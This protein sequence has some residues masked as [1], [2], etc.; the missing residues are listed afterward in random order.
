M[1]CWVW[2]DAM[3][4]NQEDATEKAEQ[5][6]E[7]HHVY[8]DATKVTVC[9]GNFGSDFGCVARFLWWAKAVRHPEGSTGRRWTQSEL[10]EQLREFNVSPSNLRDFLDEMK[11]DLQSLE[12]SGNE[13]IGCQILKDDVIGF[14]ESNVVARPMQ[15][16]HPFFVKMLE[17]LEHEWFSRLWTYQEYFL[18]LNHGSLEFLLEDHTVPLETFSDIQ[19]VTLEISES[20][21]WRNPLLQRRTLEIIR[22]RTL[23]HPVYLWSGN[24]ASL[25]PPENRLQDCGASLWSLLEASCQRRATVA[26]DHVFAVIGLMKPEM[27][28]RIRVDYLQ[29]DASTFIDAFGIAITHEGD[30]LKLSR[31]WERLALVPPIVPGLPSWCPDLENESQVNITRYPWTGFSDRIPTM[32][33]E[34]ANMRVS[35]SGK[36]LTL[37]VMKADVVA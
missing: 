15:K 21:P 24:N 33:N 2:V 13:E 37:R 12:H 27:Q 22:R 25:R 16:E 5:I 35:P 29:S 28:S 11:I 1:L 3:G 23:E 17:I 34:F 31:C 7:M 36:S 19:S 30:G 26:S 6:G 8:R 9:L 32:Y 14:E 20:N 10:V 18:A 4:I